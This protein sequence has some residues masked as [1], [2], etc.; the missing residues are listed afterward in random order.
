MVPPIATFANI[1]QPAAFT[2]L[3]LAQVSVFRRV[4][5]KW[6]VSFPNLHHLFHPTPRTA[7]YRTL[8]HGVRFIAPLMIIEFLSVLA[9]AL[10]ASWDTRDAL[11][12]IQKAAM[13]RRPYR[14]DVNCA[15]RDKM[16]NTSLGREI[17]AAS[18]IG[19]INGYPAKVAHGHR[20]VW[21]TAWTWDLQVFSTVGRMVAWERA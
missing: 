8:Q 18:S 1:I 7:I 3:M 4:V 20:F 14:L 12:P 19:A 6:H 5:H 9:L 11:E 15:R 2:V 16:K 13:N 17:V 21:I 10:L